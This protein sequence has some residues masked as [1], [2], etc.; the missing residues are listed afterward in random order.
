VNTGV[1]QPAGLV[2]LALRIVVQ[3]T[4]PQLAMQQLYVVVSSSRLI[5]FYSF[6]L[7]IF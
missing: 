4:A 6:Y 2:G 1:A 3:E 5:P 7:S